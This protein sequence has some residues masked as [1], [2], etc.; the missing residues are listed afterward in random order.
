MW[1]A[2]KISSPRAIVPVQVRI[3]LDVALPQPSGTGAIP[4]HAR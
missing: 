4:A 1:F 3:D 2:E